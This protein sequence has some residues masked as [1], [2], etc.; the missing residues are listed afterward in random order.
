M[1]KAIQAVLDKDRRFRPL[2]K[3][4]AQTNGATNAESTGSEAKAGQSPPNEPAHPAAPSRRA[5]AERIAELERRYDGPIPASLRR[6]ARVGGATEL[7]LCRAG[8]ELTVY[9]GLIRDTLAGLRT[10]RRGA[11][12][13]AR[14]AHEATLLARLRWYRDRHK[15]AL[16]R[17]LHLRRAAASK[18]HP[19][20]GT[21]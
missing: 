18:A 21:G 8:A 16:G 9:R 10:L 4:P 13:A 3:G 20:P 17:L 14:A 19:R 6:A 1:H 11:D 7:A 15:A 12:A 2:A 5:A